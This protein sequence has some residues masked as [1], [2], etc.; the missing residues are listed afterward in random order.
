M[1]NRQEVVIGIEIEYVICC[2]TAPLSIPIP[3]A[4]AN[5]MLEL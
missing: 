2:R 1:K 4:I 3:I 5:K